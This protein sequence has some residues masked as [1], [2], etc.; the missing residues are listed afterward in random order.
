MSQ[1]R[2]SLGSLQQSFSALPS[3]QVRG[4]HRLIV[5]LMSLIRSAP[6]L[7]PAYTSVLV[8]EIAEVAKASVG[9][10]RSAAQQD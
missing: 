7:S 6:P 5:G 3:N 10:C 8:K 9:S 4:E 2:A 1:A